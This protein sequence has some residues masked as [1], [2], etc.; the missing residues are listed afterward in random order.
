MRAF[1]ALLA[2]ACVAMAL[3]E[4]LL[5]TSV[6]L[7]RPVINAVEKPVQPNFEAA[8]K[9]H[10]GEIDIDQIIEIGKK[11]WEIIKAG[12]PVVDYKNDWAGVVPKN[13]KWDE[14]EGF[15]DM[16]F[17]PFGWEFKNVYGMTNINFKWHF[18][19][20]CKGSYNGHGAFLMN[21]GT[22]IEEIYVAWGYN[23]NVKA[24]VDTNPTNYGTKVDPIAG[25]TIEVT[26]EVKTVL[27]SFTERCRVSIHGDC[28]AEIL[29]CD[30]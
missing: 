10:D 21:V 17:G 14:L 8:P 2:V 30:N 11:V 25:L 18:A 7:T 9:L 13:V 15:R 6:S 12:K 19:Y 23:V 29:A 5:I 4:N 22:G 16:S 24:V 28:R 26:M 1:V 3:D 20:A 27:Q